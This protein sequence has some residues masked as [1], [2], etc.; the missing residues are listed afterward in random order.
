MAAAGAV[1]R[2]ECGF[3]GLEGFGFANGLRRAVETGKV[4]LEDWSNLSMPLRYLAGAM[5]WPFAPATVNIG[6]DLQFRS[7]FS[8]D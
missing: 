5:N 8:P 1:D 3:S 2:A 4:Q 6:S 7:A